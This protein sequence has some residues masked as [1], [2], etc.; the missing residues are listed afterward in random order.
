MYAKVWNYLRGS[1]LF[2]CESPAPERVLNLCGVYGIPFWDVQWETAERFT[3]RTTRQGAAA[4]EDAAAECGAELR[5]MEEWGA[6]TALRRMRR[7][8]VLWGTLAAVL[9]LFWYGNT[10]IWDFQVTGNETVPTEKIL[11]AL[12]NS[13]VTTGTR[14][15]S[16]DQEELRNHVLLELGDISWL[17]VNVKGCTAH[18]QVVERV[19]PP[20]LYRDSDVQNIVAARDGLITKIEALDGVT[21]AAVGET[22]QAGQVL[23]SGVADSPRGCR[24]MRATGRIWARTWYEWT[25]PVPLETVL[26]DGTEPVKTRTHTALDLGR[27]R[28]ALPAGDSILQGRENCDKIIRYRGV[29]L[30]F[31]L[32]LPVTLV[33]ETVTEPA[34]YDGQRPEGEARAEGQKQ[35]EARLAQTIGDDGRVLKAD[36]SARRQGAYLMVTLRAECEEQIGVDAPL[37]IT[38][39]TGR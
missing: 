27:H 21:C 16:F 11:R 36:V 5:R 10:F 22:V 25:V 33:R 34:V 39:D 31:G 35:L 32:R 19:R 20:H 24:Y 28:I 7:R 26:K 13:G 23:L 1:V 4:L 9:A 6:P 12:E 8:Y 15:L 3:L 17:S 18:V 29:Q 38:N 30:P 14:S 2:Q 37:T